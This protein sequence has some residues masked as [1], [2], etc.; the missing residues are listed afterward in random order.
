MQDKKDIPM[1]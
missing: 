1:V